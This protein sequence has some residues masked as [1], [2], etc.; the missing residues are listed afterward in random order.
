MYYVVTNE[1]IPG[2]D[3]PEWVRGDFLM[4]D[5]IADPILFKLLTA[6]L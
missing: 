4:A 5:D 2:A 3:L 1:V 6:S